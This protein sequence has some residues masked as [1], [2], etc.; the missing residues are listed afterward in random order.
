MLGSVFLEIGVIL[1][2]AAIGGFIAQFLRQPLI[3][4]F[5][6]IGIL[7][8]P[9]G[10]G[11]VSHSSEIELFARLGI[12]LLL[13]VVGLKLDLHIIR[14]VGP[15]ALASGLGQVL[16]TSV[17][18]YLIALLMGMSPV[19]A[20]YVAVALTFSS[21]I[22]IVKLLSDKREV[23]SLHGRIAVGFLIVQD[24]VVVLV[25]IGLTA[26]G[27]A[28]EGINIGREALV[29]LLKGALMLIGVALLMRYVLPG[30][31]QR[32]AHSSELL[33]LFAIA[34]AVLGASIGDL[35]GFSKEVGA[36]L[37][38]ISIASTAYREQVA[39]RLV[40]LR[41]F[42]LLFF[43]IELG[44]SLDILNLGGQ[45]GTAMIFSLFVLV[46]NPLIV[47]AIM[48][49]M[50]YR[51]RTGFLAGLTVAQISEFSLIL[52]ALG[53]SLGHLG[54]DTV[55]LITLVGLITI[56]VSTYMILYSHPLYARLAPWLSIFERKVA[57]R[58]L[59]T[60][61]GDEEK[62]DIL[63]IGLGRFGASVA[64][65]LR[66]RGCRLLAVDFDPQA[67]QYHT[68][69]GYAVRYGD[70]E[71]PEFIASLPLSRATWVVSTVRD[72]AIN[73][74][75]LHGL[76][77]QGYKG[78]VAISAAGSYDARF[79]EQ[80][81]VDMVLVPYTDA[82]REAAAQLFPQTKADNPQA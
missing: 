78:K 69:D 71:D 82:A 7:V 75:I 43:F 26:F 30:L 34:W 21:T 39:A 29:I 77:Q 57:Y 25:M 19:T 12:A 28:E 4:A 36:F 66:Q 70:A 22:I 54:Q 16:F 32:M 52:A 23:D 65:N 6:A 35:L 50:G 38:G 55:G 3:V 46:G 73:R 24:I 51:K 63:L 8:G 61:A 74:M 58:E 42:L 72:R 14:T 11:M 40:S 81:G 37:A 33:M 79:F 31:L 48:G 20:L 41:D 68:R 67:V 15:V 17:V 60:T 9:S 59:S 49:Y 10:F 45:L 2:L 76:K 47:M 27:Q 13:F 44:A 62:V 5:I 1:G 53:L 18:G 80:A 56:S 64:T